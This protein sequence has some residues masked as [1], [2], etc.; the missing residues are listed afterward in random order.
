MAQVGHVDGDE[1]RA[2]P[3]VL[4]T[5]TVIGAC[6]VELNTSAADAAALDLD[7]QDFSAACDDAEV[8]RQALAEWN[9]DVK[10]RRSERL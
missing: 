7:A 3:I 10:P 1:V 9:Q 6:A 2:T 4:L 5:V 8:E